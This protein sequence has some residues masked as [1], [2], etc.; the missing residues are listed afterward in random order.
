MLNMMDYSVYEAINF[1]DAS[2]CVCRVSKIKCPA[3]VV[4]AK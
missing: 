1:V 2:S 4:G 3:M